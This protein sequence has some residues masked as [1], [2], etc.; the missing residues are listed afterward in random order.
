MDLLLQHEDMY[1]NTAHLLRN[2]I[3]NAA[4]HRFQAHAEDVR[5]EFKLKKDMVNAAK[6][7]AVAGLQAAIDF[8][9][10]CR[11]NQTVVNLSQ[12]KRPRLN[13]KPS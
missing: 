11:I 1:E 9:V 5:R 7:R 4:R 3:C 13:Q 2:Y 12:K 8:H 10:M 6:S